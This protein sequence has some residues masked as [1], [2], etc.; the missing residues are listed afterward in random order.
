MNK[1]LEGWMKDLTGKGPAGLVVPVAA[2][3][4]I[5]FIILFIRRKRK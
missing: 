1:K 5:I 3:I 2:G 4:V